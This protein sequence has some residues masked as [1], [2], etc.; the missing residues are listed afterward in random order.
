MSLKFYYI[1]QKLFISI[2]NDSFEKMSKEVKYKS[3][4]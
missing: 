3:V 1:K 2:I 4:N